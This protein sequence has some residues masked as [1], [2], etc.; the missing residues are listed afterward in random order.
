MVALA[1]LCMTS[2]FQ[3]SFL[4]KTNNLSLELRVGKFRDSGPLE[5]VYYFDFFHI[6]L[7]SK[8]NNLSLGFRVGKFRDSGLLNIVCGFIFPKF[9]LK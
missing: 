9:K 1:I 5:I 2:L 3:I 8:T 7:L 4:H 6:F